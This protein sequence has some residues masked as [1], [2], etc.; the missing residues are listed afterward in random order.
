MNLDVRT[1]AGAMFIVL[2]LLLAIYGLMSDPAL[3]QRSLG[4]NINLTWG[5]VMIA[6]GGG[7]LLWRRLSP[8]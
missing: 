1:P 2:G 8:Q 5:I 3:Y 6:F 7:L 4:T